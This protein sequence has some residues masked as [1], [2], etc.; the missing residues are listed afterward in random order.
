VSVKE[1]WTKSYG[2]ERMAH[3]ATLNQLADCMDII[4]EALKGTR[5][6][7]GNASDDDSKSGKPRV[8]VPAGSDRL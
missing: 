6:D 1:D 3:A 5:A 8:R 2:P 4:A 7:F